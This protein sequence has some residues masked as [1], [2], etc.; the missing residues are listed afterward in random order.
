MIKTFLIY[1]LAL[2]LLAKYYLQIDWYDINYFQIILISIFFSF[3]Y[4]V[5]RPF[6]KLISIPLNILTFGLFSFFVNIIIIVIIYVTLR[7]F[8]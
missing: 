4:L 5:I 3:I 1:F 6:F 7:Y 8:F 2:L